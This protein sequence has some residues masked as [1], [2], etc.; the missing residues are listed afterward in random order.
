MYFNYIE[1]WGVNIYFA[2][3]LLGL[4]LF[5]YIQQESL[6]RDSDYLSFE[7]ISN[8]E[9]DKYK[10]SKYISLLGIY[11]I[12][13]LVW[14]RYLEE[15]QA[16]SIVN[17]LE[18][19]KNNHILEN[20]DFWNLYI[21][22]FC[23]GILFPIPMLVALVSSYIAISSID[24]GIIVF[25]SFATVQTIWFIYKD[26]GKIDLSDMSESFQFLTSIISFLVSVIKILSKLI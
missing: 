18:N 25:I 22:L 16:L 9:R 7:Y 2:S 1:N 4:F 10:R 5:R 21:I 11:F 24:I 13:F 19:L 8:P 14:F 26:T 15:N 3:V 12:A 17:V 6:Y 23:V 20:S